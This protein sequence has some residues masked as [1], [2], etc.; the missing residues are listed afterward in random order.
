MHILYKEYFYV[1]FKS[2]GFNLT[3]FFFGTWTFKIRT[4]NILFC[5]KYNPFVLILV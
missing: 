3:A 2:K 4:V 1:V 5:V